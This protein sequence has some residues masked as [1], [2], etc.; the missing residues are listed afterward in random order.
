MMI[1]GLN[2]LF[3]NQ[4]TS[5]NAKPMKTDE[6]E[7]V[8]ILNYKVFKSVLCVREGEG[9]MVHNCSVC[10]QGSANFAWPRMCLK[11]R[12]SCSIYFP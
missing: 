4:V 6:L 5:V 11:L 3:Q 2:F 8:G 12:M 7:S 1:E 10:M 9:C